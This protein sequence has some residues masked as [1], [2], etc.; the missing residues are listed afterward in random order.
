MLLASFVDGQLKLEAKESCSV[1]RFPV[2]KVELE[3]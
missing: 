2:P 1:E 3:T